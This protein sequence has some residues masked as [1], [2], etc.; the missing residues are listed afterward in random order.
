MLH[1]LVDFL[2]VGFNNI[3]KAPGNLSLYCLWFDDHDILFA[4]EL[5]LDVNEIQKVNNEFDLLLELVSYLGVLDV[6]KWLAHHS[7]YHVHKHQEKDNRSKEEHEPCR[8]SVVATVVA[9]H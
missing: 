4:C 2:S 1:N 6:L 9:I 7:N 5:L 8:F 3:V